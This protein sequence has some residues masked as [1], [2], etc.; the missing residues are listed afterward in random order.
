[1]FKRYIA[2]IFKTLVNNFSSVSEKSGSSFCI[3]PQRSQDFF[4]YGAVLAGGQS[5]RFGKDKARFK[6]QGISF[7]ERVCLALERSGLPVCIILKK[8]QAYYYKDSGRKILPDLYPQQTPLVGLL[9]ALESLPSEWVFVTACDMPAIC[10]R[11]IKGLIHLA[12][13]SPAE[14]II[15]VYKSRPQPL[16]GLYRRTIL[17]QARNHLRRKELSLQRLLSSLRRHLVSERLWRSLDPQGT[18]FLNINYPEDVSR[19][20]KALGRL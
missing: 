19:L 1:M 2:D 6:W 18:S 10:P 14:A 17:E 15:P 4:V 3:R 11:L 13:E 8:D 20:T 9:T 5:R 12:Q 16:L 7:V